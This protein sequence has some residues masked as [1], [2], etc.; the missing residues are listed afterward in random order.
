MS[1]AN[2]G[3]AGSAAPFDAKSDHPAA[4]ESH[5]I[6]PYLRIDTPRIAPDLGT[7]LSRR[8]ADEG[9]ENFT[10]RFDGGRKILWAS[11]KPSAIPSVTP[12]MIKDVARIQAAVRRIYAEQTD[13]SS[14]PVR[15][16]VW[17]SDMPGIWNLGG[18]LR[19]FMQLIRRR[20]RER[21]LGYAHE[22]VRAV[23]ANFINLSLPLITIALVQGDALGGGFEGALSS[24]LLIAEKSVR[25]G[26]PEILFNLFPG[27]GGY[28]L[29]ARKID[30]ATAE[31]MIFSGRIYTAT[32][33]HQ[34]GVIDVLAEEGRGEQ[35]LLEYVAQHDRNHNTHC[36]I[37]K[38][39]Q[40]C[41]P[42]TYEEMAAIAT[43]WVDTALTLEEGDLRKMERLVVAQNR[44]LERLSAMPPA[45][46]PIAPCRPA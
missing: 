12:S 23:H 15:Y 25:F 37:Y 39:R 11:L 4:M 7:V 19:L 41:N 40:R 30:A 2:F 29:L 38:V 6:A 45:G 36:A 33:L 44:R 46:G 17:A 26:L 43:I 13:P 35:R 21:L 32:E 27:M 14:R 20:D 34:M 9:I 1:S 10:I 22:V 31:R 18:D 8:L 28:S 16:M 24:N 3:S 5:A 42:V